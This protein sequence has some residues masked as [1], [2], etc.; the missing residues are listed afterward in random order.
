VRGGSLA[1]HL[2]TP[3]LVT[4]RRVHGKVDNVLAQRSPVQQ[5][6]GLKFLGGS[7]H[8]RLQYVII[9]AITSG[10]SIRRARQRRRSGLFTRESKAVL[11]H[12]PQMAGC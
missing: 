10:G 12:F 6:L 3:R 11:I 5:D 2:M 4:G 7:S 9:E 1:L 8:S